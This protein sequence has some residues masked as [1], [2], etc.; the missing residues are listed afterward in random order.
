MHL[1][2]KPTPSFTINDT[3]NP[4]LW[5]DSVLR[6]DVRHKLLMIARN[7]TETLT[8]KN[9]KLRD[10]T[11]SGSNASYNYSD[12]SDI[13]LHLIVDIDNPEL[14]DYFNAKKNNYN[15]KYDLKIKGIPVEVY[16]QDSKQ[17]HYSAGIYSILDNKWLVTP[18]KKE[19]SVSQQEIKNKARNYSA[20]IN[21]VLK[22]NDKF[23]AKETLD[24]IRRLRKAGLEQ[25]GEQSVE[26]LAFKLLRARGQLDK[27][28]KHIDKLQSAEL[29][30]GEKMKIKD[31]METYSVT[32]KDPTTGLELTAQDGT[33]M[34]LPPEKMAAI[35]ADPQDPNKNDPK[36]F[37]MSTQTLNPV[38]A[39]DHQMTGPELGDNVNLPHDSVT[40]ETQDEEEEKDLIVFNG[41]R[42]RNKRKIGGDSGDDFID[43]IIDHKW[44]NNAIGKLKESDMLYKMLTIAGLK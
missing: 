38:S 20:R 43:D 6:T 4:V 41:K 9:L 34:I 15:F 21:K 3:L 13:D 27:L 14:E 8:V 22:S 19:P 24:D 29:S 10:I 5:Q 11:V 18:S 33:K 1:S 25:G 42:R 39:D 7:F 31:I 16:V 37:I 26:N 32:K 23:A 35:Q 30:L 28:Y 40:T 44:Q 36:N 17:K 2:E 12:V